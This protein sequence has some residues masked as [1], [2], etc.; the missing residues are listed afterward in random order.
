MEQQVSRTIGHWLGWNEAMEISCSGG[1]ITILYA[2]KS[3]ISRLCPASIR[4]GLQNNLIILYIKGCTI[5]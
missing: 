5:A 3:A 2:L 4:D 1:K